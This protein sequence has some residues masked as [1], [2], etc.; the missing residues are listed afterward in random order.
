M[1]LDP[2]FGGIFILYLGG[3]C[4]SFC[5]GI[6]AGCYFSSLDRE[7]AERVASEDDGF[8]ELFN[9]NR[10]GVRIV[11]FIQGQLIDSRSINNPI[12]NESPI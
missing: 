4:Y 8:Q 10:A 1:F 11:H 2:L 6:M 5:R 7:Y 3:K 9:E 12:N